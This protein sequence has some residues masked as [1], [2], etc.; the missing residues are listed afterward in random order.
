MPRRRF[1]LADKNAL[2]ARGE[3]FVV[4]PA[5]VAKCTAAYQTDPEILLACIIVSGTLDTAVILRTEQHLAHGIAI[6][7]E[8]RTAYEAFRRVWSQ[9]TDA[10]R[11]AVMTWATRVAGR[12]DRAWRWTKPGEAVPDRSG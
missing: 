6:T 12:D 4:H 3:P 7:D 11:T 2:L 1:T 8:A 5:E 9:P 10:E